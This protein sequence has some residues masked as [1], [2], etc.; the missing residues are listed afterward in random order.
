MIESK[1]SPK[2]LET[3]Y[4]QVFK[5]KVGHPTY[6]LAR[7]V[8][9][10]EEDIPFI[11]L[12]IFKARGL[13][14]NSDELVATSGPFSNSPQGA[15]IGRAILAGK[16]TEY[17]LVPMVMDKSSEIRYEIKFYSDYPVEIYMV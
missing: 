16:N 2:N 7:M 3:S 5:I 4:H 13:G 15:V 10:G 14:T 8:S 6:V 11:G 1:N 12:K 17:Y 9:V